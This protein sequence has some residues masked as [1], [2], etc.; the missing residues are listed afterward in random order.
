MTFLLPR[1]LH[2]CQCTNLPVTIHLNLN[3]DP[4]FLSAAALQIQMLLVK[5]SL[6]SVNDSVNDSVSVPRISQEVL[7]VMRTIDDRIVHSLNTTVPTV[8]FSGKVDATQKCK[9]LYESVSVSSW[10]KWC[11]CVCVFFATLLH[12]LCFLP[13]VC[14]TDDG[15]PPEQRQSYKSLYSPDI[16]GGG[17]TARSKGGG[18][19]KP[20]DY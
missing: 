18:Q 4:E 11:V 15:G 3:H 1:Q 19:W 10:L 12:V 5:L 8:S 9:Q 13:C 2:Y 6:L 20:G 14:H 7:K 16:R 17:T